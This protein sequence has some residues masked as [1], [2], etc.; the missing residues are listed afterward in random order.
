MADTPS[1]ARSAG[2]GVRPAG[3]RSLRSPA[4]AAR[5]NRSGS[6][7]HASVIAPPM[8]GA[9]IIIR[10]ERQKRR[11]RGRDGQE[12]A[13]SVRAPA[14]ETIP[15]QVGASPP[16]PGFRLAA[17]LQRGPGCTERSCA[18]RRADGGGWQERRTER[19]TAGGRQKERRED[20]RAEGNAGRRR[21]AGKRG[22]G[23]K[24]DGARDGGGMAER[25]KRRSE[26]GRKGGTADGAQKGRTVSVR[27][28]A[29]GPRVPAVPQTGPTSVLAGRS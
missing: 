27:S 28:T 5:N 29:Q 9:M 17:S 26:G 21:E 4:P 18:G 11:E 1:P 25:A 16:P 2:K 6:P 22:D 13:G 23:R 19:V 12:P 14:G 24:A 10:R 20:R 3:A 15:R 7:G 8:S